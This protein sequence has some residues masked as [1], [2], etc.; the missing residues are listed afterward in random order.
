MDNIALL[1]LEGMGMAGYPGVAARLFGALQQ[2]GISAI[3]ISQ[4][5]GSYA[6]ISVAIDAAGAAGAKKVT[7][8]AFSSEIRH[9]TVATTVTILGT[10]FFVLCSPC[11]IVAAVGD[12]MSHTTGVA[13]RFFKAMGSASI[14]VL[15]IAQ[16]VSERNISCV[17]EQR[18]GAK[19]LRAV[20]ASFLLSQL[21]VSVGLVGAGVIGTSLMGMLVE[22][23]EVLRTQFHVDLQIRAVANAY[24]V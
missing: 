23:R 3:L 11:C 21:T 1:N 22:Q 6:L 12:G 14:N 18:Q 24:K 7:R 16:G 4:A 10:C 8:E 19:A 20:H 5:R 9:G 2:L 15:A 13:G 17:V